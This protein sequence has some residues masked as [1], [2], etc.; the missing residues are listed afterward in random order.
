MPPYFSAM[1]KSMHSALA[2][3]YTHL[4]QFDFAAYLWRSGVAAY[5]TAEL[6]DAA[7]SGE[8]RGFE[9]WPHRLRT[10]MEMCIRDSLC[11]D[12]MRGANPLSQ[13]RKTPQAAFRAHSAGS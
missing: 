12:C 4:G 9:A 2:V 5:A 7:V 6:T 11:S 3:S 8:A 10:A 13:Y 1:P